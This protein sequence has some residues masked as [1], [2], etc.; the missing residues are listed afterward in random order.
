MH[1]KRRVAVILVTLFFISIGFAALTPLRYFPFY[2]RV[3]F[4]RSISP[5]DETYQVL[6]KRIAWFPGHDVVAVPTVARVPTE[7][8]RFTL[9]SI[10]FGSVSHMLVQDGPEVFV[11]GVRPLA[12]TGSVHKVGWWV[13]TPDPPL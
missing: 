6:E 10:G 2:Q 8:L 7:Q 11:K 13:F 1:V 4:A 9:L 12:T 3:G 5:N